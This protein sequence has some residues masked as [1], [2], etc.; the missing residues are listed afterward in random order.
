MDDLKNGLHGNIHI[1]NQMLLLVIGVND[2][3]LT[4]SGK[5]QSRIMPYSY[6]LV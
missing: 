4:R 3:Q 1:V 6:R 2:S 5:I